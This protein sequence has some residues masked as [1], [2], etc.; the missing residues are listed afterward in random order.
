M[1][2]AVYLDTVPPTGTPPLDDLQMIGATTVLN[3]QVD[4][5]HPAVHD[6]DP[7]RGVYVEPVFGDHL[8]GEQQQ[9]QTGRPGE[10]A[11]AQERGGDL[12]EIRGRTGGGRFLCRGGFGRVF[13]GGQPAL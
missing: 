12:R 13:A 4:E 5:V 2:Y 11:I 9:P 6:G 3:Q 8:A 7:V 1:R 10:Y